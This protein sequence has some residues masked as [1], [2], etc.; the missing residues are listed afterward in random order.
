MEID[1]KVRVTITMKKYFQ[2][3]F[4]YAGEQRNRITS[5]SMKISG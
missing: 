1:M 4:L 5:R 3:C 2:W